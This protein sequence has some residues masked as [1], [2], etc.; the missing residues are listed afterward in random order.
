MKDDAKDVTLKMQEHK[1]MLFV[2]ILNVFVIN[3][4]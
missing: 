2:V 4:F 3:N 1:A